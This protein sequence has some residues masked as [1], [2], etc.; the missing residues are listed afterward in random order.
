VL[1]EDY[2][3]ADQLIDNWESS[4]KQRAAKAKEFAQQAASITATAKDR[5]GAVTVT[6]DSGGMITDLQL[7]DRIR[8]R[9]GHETAQ[10]VLATIRAAQAKLA[11]Q[12]ARTATDVMGEGAATKAVLDTYSKRF[13]TPV[14]DERDGR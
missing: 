3:A 4:I 10:R 2:D 1:G 13:P 12:M 9:P 11:E 8:S 6:V 7:S 5:D 14:E